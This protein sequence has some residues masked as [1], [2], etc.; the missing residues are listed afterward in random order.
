MAIPLTAREPVEFTPPNLP[1]ALKGT[2]PADS[3]KNKVR[4]LVRVPTMMERDSYAA[5]LVR[6]GVVYHTRQQIRGYALAGVLDIV[7]ESEA[8]EATALLEEYWQTTDEEERVRDEQ[9][10]KLSE[11]ME[12]AQAKKGKAAVPDPK[13]VKQELEA[14]VPNMKMDARRRARAISLNSRI[15]STYQP[16]KEAIGDQVDQDA[17]RAWL[18][19]QVYVIGWTGLPDDPDGNGSGGITLAEAEYL[20]GHIGAEAWNDLSEFIT[21]MQG[22]DQDEKKN[23]ASL[24]ESASVQIGSTTSEQ[25]SASSEDGSST[26]APSTPIPASESRKTTGSSSRSTKSSRTKTGG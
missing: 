12:A 26:D 25:S 24:L 3:T 19:A 1:E 23:L 4:I 22:I 17:K 9:M 8:D 20:R 2:D 10:K 14:I 6:G 18:N 15:M 11:L 21:S 13:V 16:L 7:P 5:A